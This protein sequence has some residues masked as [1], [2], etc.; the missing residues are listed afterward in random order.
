MFCS[1]LHGWLLTF[2]D[3]DVSFHLNRRNIIPYS[4]KQDEWQWDEMRG[5]HSVHAALAE[6][7]CLLEQPRTVLCLYLG[8]G[9]K[10]ADLNRHTG[11]AWGW[12]R[13]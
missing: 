7:A 12:H 9:G 11:S 3:K 10:E 2:G 13:G 4:G 1:A 6:A 8:Q 5:E